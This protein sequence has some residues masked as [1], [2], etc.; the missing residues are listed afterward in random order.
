MPC[1]AVG[2]EKDGLKTA[3]AN[4]DE[5][6]LKKLHKGRVDLVLAD[7]VVGTHVIN[8]ALPDAK[9]EPVWVDPPVTVDIQYLVMSKQA[10]GYETIMADFNEALSTMESDGTLAAIMAKHGF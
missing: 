2:F 4:D 7:K 5:Q 10:D 8:T 1:G 6:N 9:G 3:E